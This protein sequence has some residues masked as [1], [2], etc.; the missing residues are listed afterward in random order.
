MSTPMLIRKI[1][2]GAAGRKSIDQQVTLVTVLPPP[3]VPQEDIFVPPPPPK[4]IKSLQ[5]VK[6][7][8]P[9][10]VSSEED[11]VEEIVD[12]E[13]LKTALAGS[14]NIDASADGEVM[15]DETPVE[16]LT[17]KKIIE[18]D[19]VHDMRHVQVQPEYPGGMA[20]FMKF[21][22]DNMGNIRVDSSNDL[23]LEFRFV[24]EKDGRLTDI[25]VINDG[26]FPDIAKLATN[27][28]G[29]SPKWEPGVINGKPVRVA[30]IMPMTI[31]M[32]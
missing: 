2:G 9:P 29:W 7:F 21:V 20:A 1:G 28:L 5:E 25:R 19:R 6:K 23:K 16:Q 4:E 11:V 27:V 13:A 15:I 17:D 22:I 30:Y 12:Q 18:D 32:Q 3:D 31:K 10:V 14:Q 24:I 8:L 26:G